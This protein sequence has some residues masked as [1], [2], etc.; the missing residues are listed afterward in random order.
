[1]HNAAKMRKPNLLLA[2]VTLWICLLLTGCF[3]YNEEMW[4]KEDGSGKVTSEFVI[5]LESALG[6]LPGLSGGATPPMPSPQETGL[7]AEQMRRDLEGQK[8][9]RVVKVETTDGPGKRRVFLE[10]EFDSLADLAALKSPEGSSGPGAE[11]WKNIAWKEVDGK[12]KFERALTPGGAF[13]GSSDPASMSMAAMFFGN[14]SMNYKVHFPDKV[15]SS[16]GL[17]QQDEKTAAWSIPLTQLLAGSAPMLTAEVHKPGLPWM[18]IGIIAFLIFDGIIMA[19]AVIWALNRGKS[20]VTAAVP[21]TAA[22]TPPPAQPSLRSPDEDFR[23][24]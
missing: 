6:G 8:G 5:N 12:M 15:L 3:T 9:V 13:G 1:V 14:A 20:R 21:N 19:A 4:L 18:W 23:P 22:A 11:L 2:G 10:L 7:D 17:P 24:R 16:N